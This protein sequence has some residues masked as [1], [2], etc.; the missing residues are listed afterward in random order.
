MSAHSQPT[1]AY[2]LKQV[3]GVRAWLKAAV[4]DIET[5]KQLDALHALKYA[6]N[7]LSN[8]RRAIRQ[9]LPKAVRP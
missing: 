6:N 8:A 1:K 7:C 5:N 9:T 3:R 4:Q 2:A